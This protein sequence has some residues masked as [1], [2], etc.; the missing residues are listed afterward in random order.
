MISNRILPFSAFC[1]SLRPLLFCLF[2]TAPLAAAEPTIRNVSVRGLQVG[3]TTA[4][5]I[6]GDDLG[7]S[8]KLLLPF[9]AKQTLG[10]KSTDKQ[11]TFEVTLDAAVPPGYHHL[12]VATDGGVSLPVLIGVDRLPQRPLAAPPETLP[13]AVHGSVAGSAVAEVAFVGKA[14]QKVTVE[15]EAARLGSKLRPVAHLYSSKKLQ[16][17]WSWGTPELLGDTRLETTLPDDGTY[18]VTVHDAEYAAAAPGFFRLKIGR[19]DYA[20]AVFPPVVGAGATAVELLG[21]PVPVRVDVAGTGGDAA[22]LPWPKDSVWSGPRPFVETSTRMELLAPTAGEK[23]AELPAGPVGVCGRFTKAFGEERFRVPVTPGTKV[24]FEVF[25]ERLRSPVDAALILRNEAGADL[26]RNEDGPGTLDP[27]LEYAVPDKVTAVVVG[28]SDAQGRAGPKAVYRLTVDPVAATVG[29]GDFRLVTPAQRVGLPAGGRVVVPVFAERRGYAGRIDLS[30]IGLPPGVKLDGATI[31]ADTD[32]ALVTAIRGDAPADATITTWRGRG[33]TGVERA[34]TLKGHA[35]ERLQPWL[36]AELAVAPVAAKAG[37]F[38]ID[39]RG[40]PAAAGFVPAGKLALPVKVT[41][42]DPNTAVR[43]T[44]LTGQLP[45]LANN[46]PDAARTI[47]V[48]KA[49]ELAVKVADGEI[50]A[51]VPAELPSASYDVAVRAELL[52]ADKQKVLA[53]AFTPV[54]RLPVRVPLALKL[55]TPAKLTATLDPKAGA[56]V[57]I[58]GE[59]V[60]TEGFAGE[61]AVALTGLPAGVA[62][63][64]V[65]VK[66]GETK[67]VVKFVVPPTAAVGDVKGLK[68]AGS[69]PPD[70]KVPAVRVKS[71]DTDL[72]LTIL[73]G[74]KKP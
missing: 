51:L 67:F 9:P 15:V 64:P 2:L 27:V 17:A 70:P 52:S 3:A 56:T 49:V 6:D 58:K 44:L 74:A 54:K 20:D 7:K 65:T 57:E 12:R 61:V 26:A 5:V 41:R 46:Q 28:V 60:R 69:G 23:P 19:W 10:P 25:A 66:A 40:L 21:P 16:L 53:T 14:G 47:R 32:G 73:A 34:V 48:E 43:L 36:A 38:T 4:L 11:A 8:P 42:P 33:E 22:P 30:A 1:A 71:R 13:V 55:E 45:P 62:A 31:A 24:R 63:A 18:T 37:D 29:P 68:L 59:V 50:V 72:T 39:W 35:L